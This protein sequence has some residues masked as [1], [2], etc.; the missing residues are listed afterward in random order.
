MLSFALDSED[1]CLQGLGIG[2]CCC[3]T[4]ISIILTVYVRV[5]GAGDEA[6]EAAMEPSFTYECTWP[7][8]VLHS[9]QLVQLVLVWISAAV[10][11]Y[12]FDEPEER[13]CHLKKFAIFIPVGILSTLLV[14]WPW[15]LSPE[16][17]LTASAGWIYVMVQSPPAPSSL[18]PPWLFSLLQPSACRSTT[19]QNTPLLLRQVLPVCITS[20]GVIVALAIWQVAA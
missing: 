13:S 6:I 17:L 3:W 9:L 18:T 7:C 16:T 12:M 8:E 2:G 4:V 5:W 10:L 15:V 1:D 19:K 14:N 11:G 20:T